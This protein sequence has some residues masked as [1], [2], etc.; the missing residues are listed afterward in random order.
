MSWILKLCVL[1]CGG[2]AISRW[3]EQHYQKRRPLRSTHHASSPPR[4][5]ACITSSSPHNHPIMGTVGAL[6]FQRGKLKF[7]NLPKV[8]QAETGGVSTRT[9]VAWLYHPHM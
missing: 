8:T 9:L 1:S 5:L 6:V 4:H 3:W 2:G 7:K